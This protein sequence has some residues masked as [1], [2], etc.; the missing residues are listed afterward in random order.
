MSLLSYI[1]RLIF[2]LGGVDAILYANGLSSRRG[3]FI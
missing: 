3:E 2:T 1:G